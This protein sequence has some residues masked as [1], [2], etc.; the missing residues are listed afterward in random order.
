ME[1]E[2]INEERNEKF[3]F[4]TSSSFKQLTRNSKIKIYDEKVALEIFKDYYDNWKFYKMF[5]KNDI[6]ASFG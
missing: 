5:N 2:N 1:T 6:N 4:L 3:V